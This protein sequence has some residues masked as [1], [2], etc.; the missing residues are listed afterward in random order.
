MISVHMYDYFLQVFLQTAILCSAYVCIIMG[1]DLSL[2]II[3][4]T[5][6]ECVDIGYRTSTILFLQHVSSVAGYISVSGA[7]ILKYTCIKSYDH[8]KYVHTHMIITQT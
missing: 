6:M 3:I 2:N 4:Y 7:T 8:T 5:T 1:F